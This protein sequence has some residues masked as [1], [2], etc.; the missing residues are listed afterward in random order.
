MG[1]ERRASLRELRERKQR[2]AAA[3]GPSET[4][5]HRGEAQEQSG[6][7]TDAETQTPAWGNLVKSSTGTAAGTQALEKSKK[8]D[9]GGEGGET[10]TRG[11]GVQRQA[12]SESGEEALGPGWA[13]QSQVSGDSSTEIQAER[14]DQGQAGAGTTVMQIQ[15]P[16]TQTLAGVHKGHAEGTWARGRGKRGCAGCG[17]LTE[18]PG[19]GWEEQGQH[20]RERPG[21]TP[22]PGGESQ[23]QP[24]REVQVGRGPRGLQRGEGPGASQPPPR[25]LLREIRQEDWMVMEVLWWGD[26]APAISELVREF[27][28]PPGGKRGQDGGGHSTEAQVR[29][30]RGQKGGG[31]GCTDALAPEALAPEAEGQAQL[32]GDI[33]VEGQPSAG[34]SQEQFGKKHDNDSSTDIQAPRQR[35][36]KG[37][38]GD[39]SEDAQKPGEEKQGQL[40]REVSGDVNRP[41]WGSHQR[42]RSR[43]GADTPA[44]AA[45]DRGEQARDGQGR[46]RLMEREQE[47]RAGGEKRAEVTAPGDG[48]PRAAGAEE[49]PETWAAG[50]GDQGQLRGDTDGKA[51]LSERQNPEHRGGENGAQMEPP[52]TRNQREFG[53]EDGAETQRPERRNR[54][55][56]PR[57]TGEALPPWRRAREQAGDQDIAENQAPEKRN[58]REVGSED[59]R[60]IQKRSEVNLRLIQRKTSGDTWSSEWQNQGQTGGDSDAETQVQGDGQQS[61]TRGEDGSE[62]QAPEG[63]EQKWLRSETA[64]EIGGAAEIQGVGSQSLCGSEGAGGR[65]GSE[66]RSRGREAAGTDLQVDCSG[67][68]GPPALSGSGHEVTEQEE[69]AASAPC[70][71]GKRIPSREELIPVASGQ[72]EHLASQSSAP[73]RKGK[74]EVP[75]A[76]QQARPKPQRRRRRNQEVAPGEAS[77][78][79]EHLQNPQSL[80]APLGL[81]SACPSLSCD[82]AP[83]AAAALVGVPPALTVL[84]KWPALKKS[85]RLLLESLMRRKMAHLQWGLPQRIRA[86]HSLSDLKELHSLPLAAME[87][88]GVEGGELRGQQGAPGSR[89]V[90]KK[91]QRPPPPVR[92]NSNL[93][94]GI[95][96]LERCGPPRFQSSGISVCPEKPRRSRPPGGPR[97]PQAAQAE[98]PLRT[99]LWDPPESRSSGVPERVGALSSESGKGRNLVRPGISL[100]AERRPHS[101]TRCDSWEGEC[102]PQKPV[103]PPRRWARGS[104]A[105]THSRDPGQ[106]PCSSSSA[107]P[108]FKGGLYSAAA[109]LGR[110][111]LGKLVGG[112]PL[113]E[114][115]HSAPSLSLRDP[116][117]MSLRK[118]GDSQAGAGSVRDHTLK[119]DLQPPAHSWAAASLPKTEGPQSQGAW[120]TPNGVPQ[121]PSAPRKFGFVNYVRCFLHQH[122]FRR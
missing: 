9:R 40:S 109:G 24:R 110:T 48:R 22:E 10:Q 66:D 41:E 80:A 108:S 122:G 73:A 98:A 115:Q 65:G 27:E 5:P 35:D 104:L 25:K 18:T 88:P 39:D 90:P 53:D 99:T 57:E 84:P 68:E 63:D 87:L 21:E 69:A 70:P 89:P 60:N 3:E 17:T 26:Q 14:R 29:A 103:K 78:L 85:Q 81:A 56:S 42:L 50:E 114:P 95:R 52:E 79:T 64:S 33:H 32:R 49:G 54:R 118:G 76:P 75:A 117:P 74:V 96:T 83:Q 58:E 112:P 100:L 37:V 62:A 120:E 61:G 82:G 43:G 6:C 91:P 46:T 71:E 11:S 45:E 31:G 97:E 7:K 47:E 77:R 116:G 44:A 34:R 106:Q 2:A 72:G 4:Q 86:S 8:E 55:R 59:G 113:A 93:P 92:K 121:N 102:P 30:R 94:T 13:E 1:L 67:S 23:K 15:V 101:R 16:E 107:T 119:R 28:M 36:P 38:T 111:L 19:P 12:A 105:S 20:S 51:H